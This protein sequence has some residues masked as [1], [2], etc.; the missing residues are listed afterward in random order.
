MC[1]GLVLMRN[2]DA[3]RS[4]SRHN[5]ATDSNKQLCK[6]SKAIESCQFQTENFTFQYYSFKALLGGILQLW[7]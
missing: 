3:G 4:L 6:F 5:I 1:L 2:T 7:F